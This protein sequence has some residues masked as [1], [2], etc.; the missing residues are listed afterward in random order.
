[1]A[2]L[3]C[4]ESRAEIIDLLIDRDLKAL[5]NREETFLDLRSKSG[6]SVYMQHEQSRA[7]QFKSFVKFMDGKAQGAVTSKRSQALLA[8][9]AKKSAPR[10]A[11]KDLPQNKLKPSAEP[12]KPGNNGDA[13]DDGLDSLEKLRQTRKAEEAASRKKKAEE[14]KTVTPI[15]EETRRPEDRSVIVGRHDDNM[16]N[17]QKRRTNTMNFD[18]KS[19]QERAKK[20]KRPVSVKSS[21]TQSKGQGDGAKKM[22]GFLDVSD[23][24]LRKLKLH[25]MRTRSAEMVISFLYGTNIDGKSLFLFLFLVSISSN[26]FSLSL[27]LS[28]LFRYPPLRREQSVA[29]VALK[30]SKSALTMTGCLP[31][32]HGRSSSS[33]SAKTKV[34]A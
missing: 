2:F 25:Y 8:D 4:T 24:I 1:M 27:S 3:Q 14:T 19:E 9:G 11:P 23:T 5:R 26:S 18:V 16:P 29:D 22:F 30:M 33:A 15:D 28:N 13:G 31:R 34:P 20:E 6:N 7:P 17:T 12:D 32:C 21:S 10:S